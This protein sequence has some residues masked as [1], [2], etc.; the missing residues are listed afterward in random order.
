MWAAHRNQKEVAAFLLCH[1]KID[2]N[3]AA[4]VRGRATGII[5]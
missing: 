3:Q 5:R 4:E 2:V 1:P